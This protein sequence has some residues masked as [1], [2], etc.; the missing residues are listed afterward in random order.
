MRVTHPGQAGQELNSS[1]GLFATWQPI[2]A[3]HNIATVP[4]SPDKRPLVK[5]PQRF[6]AVASGGIAHKFSTANALGFYAGAKN[7]ITVLD[8][9]TTDE[10]A[11]ADALI[12]HGD[13]PLITRTASGKFHALYRHNGERR[14]IRPWQEL[15]IDVLGGGCAFCRHR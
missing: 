10:R 12:R 7:G 11:L 6:G 14:H 5:N 3:A 1:C 8:I 2:Y 15:P 13:T 4:C 9:D